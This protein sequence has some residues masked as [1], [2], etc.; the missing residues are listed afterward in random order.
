[1]L[2]GVDRIVKKSAP[3]VVNSPLTSGLSEGFFS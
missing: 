2:K 1:M 3:A